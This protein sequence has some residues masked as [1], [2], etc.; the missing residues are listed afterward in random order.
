VSTITVRLDPEEEEM[1]DRLAE[2]HG[3]RS[4]ALRA[5]LRLL[6]AN[7]AGQAALA[8]LLAEWELEDGPV[9][10]AAADR[11]IDEYRL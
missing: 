10:R 1:L 11:M 3:G 9:D 4:G 6:A 2:I 7:T 8:G 5:G